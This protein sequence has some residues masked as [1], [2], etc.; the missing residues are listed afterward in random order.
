MGAWIRV[1]VLH[2]GH[3]FGVDLEAWSRY[4]YQKARQNKHSERRVG[5]SRELSQNPEARPVTWNEGSILLQA[6]HDYDAAADARIRPHCRANRLLL[7]EDESRTNR[8][9]RKKTSTA[10][11]QSTGILLQT[12][13]TLTT[14]PR[15]GICM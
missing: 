6:I 13:L 14:L 15:Q 10:K 3:G 8:E 7:I 1:Y 11:W 12:L 5:R 2:R 9:D 4:S